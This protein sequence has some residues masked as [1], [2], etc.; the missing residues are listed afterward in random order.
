MTAI[1]VILL[2]AGFIFEILSV[3]RLFKNMK[4]Y[5]KYNFT[6]ATIFFHYLFNWYDLKYMTSARSE[7]RTRATHL[8]VKSFVLTMAGFALGDSSRI[9]RNL[10][11]EAW[12]FEKWTV[13]PA[14]QAF[15]Y[16]T[17]VVWFFFFFPIACLLLRW[18]LHKCL[19]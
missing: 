3:V 12:A 14:E 19:D 8:I 18:F 17:C 10:M 7:S 15:I 1:L 6:K 13:S 9:I 4:R 2:V 11:Y 5:S 16:F